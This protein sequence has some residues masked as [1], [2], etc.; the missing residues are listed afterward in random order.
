MQG[1]NE[2]YLSLDEDNFNSLLPVYSGKYRKAI[3]A[4]EEQIKARQ[5]ELKRIKKSH[6]KKI[7]LAYKSGE[8]LGDSIYLIFGEIASGIFKLIGL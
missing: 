6:R 4:Q 5:E 2:E 1:E 3:S 7:C 8:E